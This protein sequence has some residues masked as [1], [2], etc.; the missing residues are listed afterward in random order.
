[1]TAATAARVNRQPAAQI[2]SKGGCVQGKKVDIDKATFD[3]VVDPA[4]MVNP[5]VAAAA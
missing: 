3:R 2:V 5:Y 4:K 1:L